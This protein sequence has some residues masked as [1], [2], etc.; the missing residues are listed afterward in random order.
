MAILP[1]IAIGMCDMTARVLV[2]DDNPLSLEFL[3]AA[4][5]GFGLGCETAADGEAALAKAS[6]H[7]FDLVLLDARMPRRSGAEALA[8]IR[9][10]RG[11]SS[12]V[13][14]RATTAAATPETRAALLGAGFLDVLLKPLAIAE[15][16][17]ALLAHVPSRDE[18][19]TAAVARLDDRSAL[20]AA[21]GDAAIVAALRGLFASE[22]DALPAEIRQIG[23]RRDAAAL[24]ERLHRLDASAGFCGAP[25]LKAAAATLRSTLAASPEWPDRAMDD[26]LAAC[27][28]VRALLA[29][30]S[31]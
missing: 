27:E 1:A 11:P 21:G 31:G 14:A 9:R 3:A 16:H 13:P 4:I 10:G 12:A 30:A 26:F 19:A 15:L 23:A 25:T 22:L 18:M 7:A 8:A 28:R 5:L 6:A 29:H 20:A 24:H 2:A 17:A